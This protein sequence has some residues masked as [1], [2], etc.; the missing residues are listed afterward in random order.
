MLITQRDS[1]RV[2]IKRPTC[3]QTGTRLKGWRQSSGCGLA[4]HLASI[5]DVSKTERY[6]EVETIKW[7]RASY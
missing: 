7:L 5:S 6:E 2:G 1:E 3:L 4:M